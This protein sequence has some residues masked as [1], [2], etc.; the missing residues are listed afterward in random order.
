MVTGDQYAIAV[1]TSR[2]LG[3]GTNIM[4]G[5]ELLSSKAT[6]MEFAKH[7]EAMDGFAGVFPE[8]KHRIVEAMQYSGRLVGMTGN[9]EVHCKEAHRF[10]SC[11]QLSGFCLQQALVCWEQ[12]SGAESCC[13]CKSAQM[14]KT[15]AR[16]RQKPDT[17]DFSHFCWVTGTSVLGATVWLLADAVLRG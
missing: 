5:E 6:N 16:H 9:H 17:A 2:R 10:K 11:R 4:E 3:L 15:K 7:V 1:E 13:P 8:H 14:T 12:C